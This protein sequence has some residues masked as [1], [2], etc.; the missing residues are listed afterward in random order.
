MHRIL[1]LGLDPSRYKYEGV[2]TH[3]PVIQTIPLSIEDVDIAG[4]THLLFTSPTAVAYWPL[5]FEGK[6]LIA[7]GQGTAAKLNLPCLIAP[8]ATQEGVIELLESMDLSDA[9]ILWPRSSKSRS[10]LENY[11]REKKSKLGS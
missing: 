5:S 3:F 10:C 1:Y 11:F 8:V 6:V 4:V 9:L 2:L 7:I